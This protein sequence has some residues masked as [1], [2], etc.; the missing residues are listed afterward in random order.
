M[1]L[2]G[3]WLTEC[4][5]RC[6]YK[7]LRCGYWRLRFT[8]SERPF[9]RFAAGSG[10][11]GCAVALD[12]DDEEGTTAVTDLGSCGQLARVCFPLQYRQV[13][14]RKHLSSPNRQE[15][16]LKLRQISSIFAVPFCLRFGVV[17]G[18]GPV[19]AA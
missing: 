4:G 17:V 1:W 13:W 12:D 15:P 7:L 5:C 3:Y 16:V 18:T 14:R 9:P 8:D 10:C 11:F 19:N 6:R 2:I